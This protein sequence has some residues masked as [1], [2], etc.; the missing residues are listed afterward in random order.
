MHLFKWVLLLTEM[1]DN[2]TLSYTSNIEI[3]PP[4]D[5]RAVISEDA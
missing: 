3:P 4:P 2:P 5:P 1:T